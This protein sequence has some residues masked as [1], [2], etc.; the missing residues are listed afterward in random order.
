MKNNIWNKVRRLIFP[1]GHKIV[2]SSSGLI[3]PLKGKFK[4]LTLCANKKGYM[5]LHEKDDKTGEYKS[6]M[7][8]PFIKLKRIEEDMKKTLPSMFENFRINPKDKRKKN[9]RVFILKTKE[10]LKKRGLFIQKGK[11][12][13]ISEKFSNK[14]LG[15]YGNVFPLKDINKHKVFDSSIKFIINKKNKIVDTLIASEIGYF[16]VNKMGKVIENIFFKHLPEWKNKK[17]NN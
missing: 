11:N 7:K 16:S 6:L 17:H 13:I 10:E 2:R 15:K 12:L 3:F 4:H 9:M 5:D 8:I 14:D 1:G